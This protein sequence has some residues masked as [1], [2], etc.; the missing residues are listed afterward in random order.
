[1]T[2]HKLTQDVIESILEENTG[3]D[4]LTLAQQS[5][6]QAKIKLMAEKIYDMLS[7]LNLLKNN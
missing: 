6:I 1:M 2:R 3:I 7:E 5:L 4:S